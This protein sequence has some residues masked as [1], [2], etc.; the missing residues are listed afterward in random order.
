MGGEYAS[1][2]AIHRK[3]NQNLISV[4]QKPL[5]GNQNN[6]C[7]VFNWRGGGMGNQFPLG[8]ILFFSLTLQ[9]KL[10]IHTWNGY[11]ILQHLNGGKTLPVEKDKRIS[12]V[13]E[14]IIYPEV[15]PEQVGKDSMCKFMM[16]ISLCKHHSILRS[17]N[18][19]KEQTYFV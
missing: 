8:E 6:S 1:S 17:F 5:F 12:R 15:T 9:N 11:T 19:H 13:A 7:A 10:C 18:L 2:C 3:L 14:I 4:S 16:M